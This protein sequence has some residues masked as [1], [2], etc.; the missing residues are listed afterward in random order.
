MFGGWEVRISQ[1][2][3]ALAQH[4]E[5]EV[6]IL[7]ADHGQPHIEYIENVRLISWVGKEI[8]GV[9][10]IRP[11]QSTE[12]QGPTPELPPE[13]KLIGPDIE[14]NQDRHNDPSTTDQKEK[15][16]NSL[17]ML[18]RSFLR[19]VKTIYRRVTPWKARLILAGLKAGSRAGFDQFSIYT[20]QAIK[21]FFVGLKLS[22]SAFWG[23]LR[24]SL[25]T[26]I[27]AI[28]HIGDQPVFMDT[29]RIY[30]E[31][32]ADVYVVPGNNWI[33]SEVAFYCQF[34]KKTFV[35]LAGS[36]MDFNPEFFTDPNKSDLY[37]AP[38]YLKRYVIEK[39]HAYIVQNENQ[40]KLARQV[41]VSPILIRNPIS[42]KREEPKDDDGRTVLWIGN[43]DERVKRPSL[44][45]E[46]SRCLP[47]YKFITVVTPVL[48]EDYDRLV[49]IARDIPNL[50]ITTRVPYKEIEKYF[51]QATLFVNTSTLEGFPNTFLQAGKYGVP[52][53][54]LKVDP[55]EMLSTYG[56]GIACDDDF[57]VLIKSVVALI[58]DRTLYTQ[59]STNILN[60]VKEYH[61][62]DLI[63]NQY[64]DFFRKLD[65]EQGL[66]VRV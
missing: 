14:P 51:A 26:A 40:L 49:E 22:F 15:K 46:L 37:G 20:R 56:C 53:I 57:D 48:E 42:L 12:R 2:A 6:S 38:Y 8:W 54:S 10:F 25:E 35:M 13:E 47:E 32:D 21:S 24:G 66:T 55:N 5:Y 4:S 58:K 23:Y 41:G 28:G 31:I 43:T 9:P 33:S 1:I 59:Y 64:L 17:S 61:D 11:D 27:N 44:I 63:I 29:L 52:V 50:E 39:A 45:L 62:I 7:V 19:A 16:P 30:Q 60:Y 18:Y 65:L 3:K 34:R 36:D